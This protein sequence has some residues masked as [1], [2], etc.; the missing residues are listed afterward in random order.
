MNRPKRPT[1]HPAHVWMGNEQI[2]HENYVTREM[3]LDAGEPE[4]E[5]MTI[6][7]PVE[8]QEVWEDH[9]VLLLSET[10]A[11]ITAIERERDEAIA[12]VRRNREAFVNDLYEDTMWRIIEADDKFLARIEGE[13]NG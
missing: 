4:T 10:D 5:G 8:E 3:A 7:G 1:P 6:A 2:E 12:L 13:D 9:E 11:Y